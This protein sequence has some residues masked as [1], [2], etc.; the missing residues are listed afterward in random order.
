MFFLG[1]SSLSKLEGVDSSLIAVV[2]RAIELT[3]TDF[4]VIE[5]RR[6]KARQEELV[7]KGKSQTMKSNHLTGR[8]VD[9]LALTKPGGSWDVADYFPIA[10]AFQQAAKELGVKMRW[11]GAWTCYDIGNSIGTMRQHHAEYLGICES[12]GR[13]PFIDSPHFE[14]S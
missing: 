13:S 14:I 5:G 6:T 4:Q 11:G 8:A 2:K 9:I 1:S 12:E 7:K 10:D 3:P